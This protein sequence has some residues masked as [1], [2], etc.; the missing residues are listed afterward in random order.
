MKTIAEL[1]LLYAR[2]MEKKEKLIL[3]YSCCY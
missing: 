1:F 3:G 2:P